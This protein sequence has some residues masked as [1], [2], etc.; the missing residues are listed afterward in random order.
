MVLNC[1]IYQV[2]NGQRHR[3]LMWESFLLAQ[4]GLVLGIYRFVL[5]VTCRWRNSY[6]WFFGIEGPC[7][8]SPQ[9]PPAIPKLKK[10]KRE[11]VLASYNGSKMSRQ[12]RLRPCWQLLACARRP[13][14]V[15][16]GR[17]APAPGSALSR[18]AWPRPPDPT[19][20]QSEP[21]ACCHVL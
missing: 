3:V 5:E 13:E 18:W 9:P 21:G 17:R 4:R 14:A 7:I 10:E 20:A 16:V 12:L 11:F 2:A 15:Q 19:R 1:V 6:S 8:P